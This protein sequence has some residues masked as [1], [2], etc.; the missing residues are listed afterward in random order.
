MNINNHV[1]VTD[2]KWPFSVFNMPSIW[3]K[4]EDI[5]NLMQSFKRPRHI[6]PSSYDFKINF[7]SN[8]ILKYCMHHHILV[9]NESELQAIFTKEFQSSGMIS[10]PLCLG[11]VLQHMI[12]DGKLQEASK[13]NYSGNLATKVMSGLIWS[14]TAPI[15]WGYNKL[16]LSLSS[17]IEVEY[18][19]VQSL[20]DFVVLDALRMG[21][22]EFIKWI[23]ESDKYHISP[24][25][26]VMTL[27]DF[28]KFLFCYY[29][30]EASRNVARQTLISNR[31]IEI[32]TLPTSGSQVVRFI[33]NAENP[34]STTNSESPS[35]D[36]QTLE[37]INAIVNLR[38]VASRLAADEI[39]VETKLDAIKER[40]RSL[41]RADRFEFIIHSSNI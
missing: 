7:W 13:F 21:Q 15:K 28:D 3:F 33:V 41:L 12:G 6:D 16:S 35:V 25:L 37:Q 36:R 34:L 31:F 18:D 9:I 20:G 8:L 2:L 27:S 32:L 40:V 24:Q 22:N 23:A 5:Y 29:P 30:H 4:D 19:E 39:E 10:K 26:N 17:D 1:K 14:I 38:N 11:I